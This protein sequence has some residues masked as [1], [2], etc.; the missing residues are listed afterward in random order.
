MI[1]VHIKKHLDSLGF[2]N[3]RPA[4]EKAIQAGLFQ[5]KNLLV[6]TP[7]ASGKTLVGE[8]AILH[9]IIDKHK[10]GIYV[11]PLRAL[12]REKYKEFTK[13]HSALKIALSSGDLDSDDRYLENYDVVIVTSEK[14]DSLLRHHTPWL[15]RVGVVV[16]DEVHL[17]NDTS[18][19]PTL[20]VVI[21]LLRQELKN[22]QLIALSATVGNAQELASW[23]DATL[24]E[25]SWRPVRLDKAVFYQ[26][27][28]YFDDAQEEEKEEE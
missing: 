8:L 6:C 17:L 28:I 4:Q 27:T 11:V 23:L 14:L 19:G 21:T 1:P 7:T 24:V 3:L 26:D 20:E 2:E 5:E 16:I 25:D 18:R 12:A 13:K 10:K 15:G 9:T 22:L